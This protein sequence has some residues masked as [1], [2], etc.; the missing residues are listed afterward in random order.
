MEYKCIV[1]K[2]FKKTLKMICGTKRRENL[3]FGKELE[4][5]QRTVITESRTFMLFSIYYNSHYL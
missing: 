2:N 4:M 1:D 5:L 3:G